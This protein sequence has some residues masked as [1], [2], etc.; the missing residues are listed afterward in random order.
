MTEEQEPTFLEMTVTCRTPGC[1]NADVPL[2][3]TVVQPPYVVCGVC[4]QQITDVA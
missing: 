1:D 3:L 4:G 2:V